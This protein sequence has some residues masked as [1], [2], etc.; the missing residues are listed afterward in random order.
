MICECGGKY[1]VKDT[2]SVDGITYRR[3]ECKCCGKSVFTK[4]DKVNSTEAR[5]YMGLAIRDYPVFRSEQPRTEKRCPRCGETKPVS[6]FGRNRIRGKEC[7]KSYC[8]EC[9]RA[10]NKEYSMRNF[11]R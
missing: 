7:L 9:S 3:R 10:Y 5:T 11:W 4:E 1:S 8:K 6:E 2:R